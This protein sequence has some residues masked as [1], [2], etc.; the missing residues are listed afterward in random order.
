MSDEALFDNRIVDRNIHRELITRE[1]YEKY[2]ES[3]E[4]CAD[5]AEETETKM[6]FKSAED[7]QAD[8]ATTEEA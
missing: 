8:D 3:L 2:L 4:D 1:D 5:L 6:V 7:D